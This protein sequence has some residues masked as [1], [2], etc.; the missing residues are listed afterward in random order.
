MVMEQDFD[1]SQH[2][3]IQKIPKFSMRASGFFFQD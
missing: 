1:S 2:P 3:Q